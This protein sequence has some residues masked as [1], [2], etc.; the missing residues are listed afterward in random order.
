MPHETT[1]RAHV[2]M[3][4]VETD[5]VPD[6]LVGD[7][8][9][10]TVRLERSRLLRD[11]VALRLVSRIASETGLDADEEWQRYLVYRALSSAIWV[12][13][14]AELR[15]E[16]VDEAIFSEMFDWLIDEAP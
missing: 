11:G 14:D 2:A 4:M 7:R 5:S 3:A 15:E 1:T 13:S 12:R 6:G 10:E 16:Q 9:R 8:V